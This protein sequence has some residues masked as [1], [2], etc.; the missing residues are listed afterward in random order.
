MLLKKL[1]TYIKKQDTDKVLLL[2]EEFNHLTETFANVEV[3]NSV[4]R[5]SDLYLELVN[6]ETDETVESD[7]PYSFLDSQMNYFEKNIENYLYIESSAF[8]I[9]SAESFMIEVDSVFSTYELILGLQLP[10]KKEKDIRNYINANLQE[11]SASFQLLFNDK[12]GLWELNLPL[13]KINGFDKNMTLAESIKLA[14]L[15]LFN[16]GIALER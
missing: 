14:Y 9:I 6:K 5:F 12:D 15:F 4:D 2:E 8:E 7:L 10:K 11:E 13:D 1:E 3:V 16:L